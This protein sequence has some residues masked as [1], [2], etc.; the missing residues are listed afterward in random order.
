MDIFNSLEWLYIDIANNY[1][2]DKES[3]HDR[4]TWAYKHESYLHQFLQEAE[5]PELFLK[6]IRALEQVKL[7]NPTG[8]VTRLDATA[9]GLQIMAIM[10][11][12]LASATASNLTD[13]LCRRD[14]YIIIANKMNEQ[15]SSANQVTKDMIK[16]PFMS[17][18]FCKEKH[19]T[20]N[21]IQEEVFH[22]TLKGIFAGA[23]NYRDVIKSCWDKT[24][25]EHSWTLPDGHR[26]VCKVT[27]TVNTLFYL[28]DDL[29]M[30][31]RHTINTPSTK[32]TPLVANVTHSIDG[33]IAREM[34]RRAH[35]KG[36]PLAHIHD[37]F[38]ASPKYM[39]IVRQLYIDILC[40]IAD[41]TLLQDILRE[42]TGNRFLVYQKGC[43]NLSEYIRE[44]N[45]ALS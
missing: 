21:P 4:L 24:A 3:W 41:S 37:C 36:F 1:G 13:P 31:Y 9:S 14:V 29:T 15:L 35:V 44:S 17:H 42:I 32:Y 25:L 20:L 11:G 16:K 12:C 40:E 28:P 43:N 23:E 22:A 39:N 33:Y 7:G 5:Q 34:V 18:F 45:Y 27:K 38:Y 8:I 30:V 10:V 19:E 26:A 6:G 2:L